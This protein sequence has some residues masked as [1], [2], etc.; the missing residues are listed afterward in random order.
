MGVEV[1]L[2]LGVGAGF[3]VDWEIG[4]DGATEGW[5]EE[6]VKE[7]EYGDM[8]TWEGRRERVG[9][10]GWVECEEEWSGERNRID[11]VRERH[12]I[13]GRSLSLTNDQ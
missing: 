6:E 5:E 9:S 4:G 7:G 11:R 10:E 3:K 2:V 8:D 13:V 12:D 1:R